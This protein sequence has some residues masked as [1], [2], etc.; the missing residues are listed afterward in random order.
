MRVKTGASS[1]TLFSFVPDGMGRAAG[2]ARGR[3]GCPLSTRHGCHRDS[4]HTLKQNAVGSLIDQG[5]HPMKAIGVDSV[6]P[7]SMKK[8]A[9]FSVPLGRVRD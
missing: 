2:V 1:E 9:P 8:A 6:R 4:E 7:S 5:L 3:P